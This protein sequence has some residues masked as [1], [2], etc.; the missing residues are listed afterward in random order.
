MIQM[1][2]AFCLSREHW[3]KH[4]LTSVAAVNAEWEGAESGRVNE[5]EVGGVAFRKYMK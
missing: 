4:V 1:K 2:K 5:G 3:R